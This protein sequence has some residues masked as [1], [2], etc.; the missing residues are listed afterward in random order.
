MPTDLTGQTIAS[1][2]GQILHVD[3]GV[4][5]T[6]K[7]VND[8]DGTATALQVGTTS[9]NVNGDLLVGGETAFVDTAQIKDDAVTIAKLAATG[10]PS[11]TTYL[12]GDNTWATAGGGAPD[13]QTF[14]ASGTWTKPASGSMA[15]IQVWGGGGG[16]G[17]GTRNDYHSGGGGGGYNEITVPLSTLA[18]TETVTIGAAGAGRTGSTGNGTAGGNSSFGSVCLAYGGSGGRGGTTAVGG[19][20]GGGWLSAGNLSNNGGPNISFTQSNSTSVYNASFLGR[21]G[22]ISCGSVSSFAI[23]GIFHGGGSHASSTTATAGGSIYGGGAGASGINTGGVSLY[24][25]NG[26]GPNTVGTAPGGG[27]GGSS[28]ANGNGSNGAAGRVI[29]TVY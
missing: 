24:G 27:G 17:R 20:G 21:G 4:T 2:Y 5:S 25:G 12:R 22:D 29:V 6:R 9:V 13:V 7:T 14:D 11:A 8:G 19:A 3:G 26:G 23:G 18:A 10:T 28:S 1:T 16:A 15:R